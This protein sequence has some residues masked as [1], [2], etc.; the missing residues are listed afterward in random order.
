MC[1]QPCVVRLDTVADD[2]KLKSILNFLWQAGIS[3]NGAFQ[4]LSLSE[5]VRKHDGKYVRASNSRYP[6][7]YSC[8]YGLQ[9]PSG[10]PKVIADCP[11]DDGDPLWIEP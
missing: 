7:H 3:L 6:L 9:W 4:V 2:D 1:S 5:L 10:W 8:P 11:I